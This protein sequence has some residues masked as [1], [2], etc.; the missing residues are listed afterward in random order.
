VD[1]GNKS[2]AAPAN[3]PMWYT[4]QAN[5]MRASKLIGTKVVNASNENV[6]D[7]N[8]IVLSKD[9]KVAAVVIGVGFSWNG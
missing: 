3:K 2:A 5:D 7:I 6:G 4:H 1:T 8:E 9:G